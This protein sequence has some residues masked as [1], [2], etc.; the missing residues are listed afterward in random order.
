MK[1]TSCWNTPF[2]SQCYTHFHSFLWD[3]AL[4]TTSKYFMTQSQK[5]YE[6]KS[7]KLDGVMKEYMGFYAG[8]MRQTQLSWM[9]ESQL[10]TFGFKCHFF[11]HVLFG[12]GMKPWPFCNVF[13]TWGISAFSF[14][15]RRVSP[16]LQR[17]KRCGDAKETSNWNYFESCAMCNT[18]RLNSCSSAWM[19]RC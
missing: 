9:T 5:N 16:H 18:K 14:M 13:C 17:H 11:F 10:K 19:K 3:Q 15:E 4:R 6:H 2:V 7:W 1:Q 8:K 12:L